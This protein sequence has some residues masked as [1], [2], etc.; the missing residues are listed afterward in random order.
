[1]TLLKKSKTA[2]PTAL[3]I[4]LISLAIMGF[5]YAH[6]SEN[7]WLSG[8][9][10]MGD[11]CAEFVDVDNKDLGLDWNCDNGINEYWQIDKDI[12][13]TTVYIVEDGECPNTIKVIMDNVYPCYYENI[14]MHI[15]NCGTIPW[16][17]VRVNF[18]TPY[19]QKSITG[20]Q[21]LTLDM[22]GDGK[23][24]VEIKWGDNFGQQTDPCTELEVSF[25]IHVLQDAPED[26]TMTF[27]VTIIIINW[28]E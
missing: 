16:K 4:T 25:K 8:Y 7:L 21:Y 24:D 17:I 5:T 12:G 3:A 27:T 28:N 18:T 1:M 10:E 2:I 13:S 26:T 14:E 9:V 15:H 19:E 6:W 22:S 11:M 23:A 20:P